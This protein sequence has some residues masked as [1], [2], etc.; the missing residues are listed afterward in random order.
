MEVSA[1]DVPSLARLT[2]EYTVWLQVK[3]RAAWKF[4]HRATGATAESPSARQVYGLLSSHITQPRG[5]REGRLQERA[6]P[7]MRLG[8][9]RINMAGEETPVTEWVRIVRKEFQEIPGQRLTKPQVQR[10]WGLDEDTCDALVEALVQAQFLT[11]TSTGA[12][13]RADI[14]N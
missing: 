3:F 10:L 11:R 7:Q 8:A 13:A 4:S 2:S 5:I 9:K 14:G 12:Y 1:K 6:N